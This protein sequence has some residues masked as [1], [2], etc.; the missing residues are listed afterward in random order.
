MWLG[1][2]R[3]A[4]A[5]MPRKEMLH[6]ACSL[7]RA[8]YS[9]STFRGTRARHANSQIGIGTAWS[10]GRTRAAG[11]V[12]LSRTIL[13]QVPERWPDVLLW[14]GENRVTGPDRWTDVDG[15]LSCH[16][17]RTE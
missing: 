13:P 1:Y 9:S 17:P 10:V 8:W 12:F 6:C 4:G 5:E 16:V 14:A 3:D 7:L 15:K 11:E 2:A